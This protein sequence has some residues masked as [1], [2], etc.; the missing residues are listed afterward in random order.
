MGYERRPFNPT[1]PY[2]NQVVVELNKANDNFDLLG[3]A[4]VS[5]NP[6]T[7]KVKNADTVDGF[8][9][10][11][12]PT[13]NTIPVALPNG[14][15]DIGWLPVG[16]DGYRRV[17]LTGAT[18]DYMLQVGEEAIINFT[19]AMSVPLRIETS[20]N[21]L[22]EIFLQ[23]SVNLNLLNQF[24]YLNPNNT[25]YASSFGFLGYY[26][27][28]GGSVGFDSHSTSDRAFKILTQTPHA[29]II[30]DTTRRILKGISGYERGDVNFG[31]AVLVSKWHSNLYDWLSLGTF[32]FPT[33]MSGYILV[34]R[35]L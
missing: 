34:R 25:T 26:F 4:F 27:D 8:H 12:T 30:L 9:A 3:Q 24:T 31:F 32:T 20:Q 29:Y 13:A 7:L 35:L 28:S 19:N 17:D 10:S 33:L 1:T 18:S 22:Y 15:L 5:D 14:K 11:Q 23:F 16:I 2:P 6:E 21:R